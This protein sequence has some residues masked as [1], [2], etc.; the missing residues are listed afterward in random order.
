MTLIRISYDPCSVEIDSTPCN[1]FPLESTLMCSSSLHHTRL[2]LITLDTTHPRSNCCPLALF[3]LS[4]PSKTMT[5]Q[6]GRRRMSSS[7]T[8]AATKS[9]RRWR[10][11]STTPS[12]EAVGKRRGRRRRLE[13]SRNASKCRRAR[14]RKRKRK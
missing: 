6:L 5:K 8:T 4:P 10:R 1:R 12:W 7:S 11:M 14:R 13:E 9:T 3:H 2:L